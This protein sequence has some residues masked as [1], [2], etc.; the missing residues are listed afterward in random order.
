MNKTELI[1][2][3]AN[4]LEAKQTEIG[5]IVENIFEEI[6]NA[7]A[8][9]EEISICGFG[10]FVRKEVKGREGVCKIPTANGKAWKTEDSYGISFKPGK[11]FKELV[12]G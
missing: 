2:G 12:K 4:K 1:K 5:T 6:K 3:V 9:G 10:K 11:E 8:S 7:I